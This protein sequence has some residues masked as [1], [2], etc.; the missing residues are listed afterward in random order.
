MYI[1]IYI[2]IQPPAPSPHFCLCVCLCVFVC[3]PV[4]LNSIDRIFTIS[5]L[6][7]ISFRV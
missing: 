6:S 1:F 4:A 5:V 3:L 7:I 2:Y